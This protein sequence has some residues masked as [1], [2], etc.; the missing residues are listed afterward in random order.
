MQ[1]EKTKNI[2]ENIAKVRSCGNKPFI[3]DQETLTY[4]SALDRIERLTQLYRNMGLQAGDRVIIATI[5]DSDTVI[6]FLSLLANGITAVPVNP[7]TKENR[8]RSLF[9]LTEPAALILDADLC[10][11]WQQGS[12]VP[13]LKIQKQERASTLLR[14]LLGSAKSLNQETN[15][16]PAIL[17]SLVPTTPSVD[18]DPSSDA[19]ILFTSGTTSDSKGVRITH[20]NLFA[21]LQTLSHQFGY[22]QDS[23]ILNILALH[24]ADGII[25]GPVIAFFNGASIYRPM[26]FNISNIEALLDTIYTYRISHFVAVPTM[27]ALI[28]KLGQNYSES[29]QTDDFQF[30]ISTGGYLEAKLWQDFEK[31]FGT[32]IANVYGLTETVIGSIFCGPD[33]ET[34]KRGTIGKPVDCKAR[35]VDDKGN[36][37]GSGK[38]GELLLSGSNVMP[39]YLSPTQ[40]GNDILQ[41]NWLGTGDLAQCDSQ[42]FFRIVGRKKSIIVSGGINIHPEEISEV[43]NQIP[44]VLEAVTFGIP[45]D[46]WGERVGS[47]VVTKPDYHIDEQTI[48]DYCREHLE[49]EK[50]PS[51][52]HLLDSLPKGPAGKVILPEVQDLVA[53][54]S[55]KEQNNH[56]DDIWKVVLETAAISFTVA[57]SSLSPEISAQ[58]LS[59]WTSLTHLEF[60]ASLEKKCN[61]VFMPVEIMRIEHLRDVVKIIR[62]KR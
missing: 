34:Y 13:V 9:R 8:V 1:I 49:A 47:C 62:E 50:I 44:E 46:I 37:V 48:I 24:H 57:E 53:S 18:I 21:H 27:L 26:L 29:F 31:H 43:L 55:F 20:R 23:R 38:T 36:Q 42:G 17:N 40:P 6:F 54:L 3:I 56:I 28:E 33:D 10:S 7:Q 52:I 35:I 59:G 41:N 11:L 2:Q 22:N 12:D 25:Q 39:G 5:H 15:T 14:R 60:I 61:I 4:A 19:Y 16:Y 45:D 30:V 58:D 32:R 51:T